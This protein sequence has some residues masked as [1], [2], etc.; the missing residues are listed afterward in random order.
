VESICLT[1]DFLE[2]GMVADVGFVFCG[3][4]CGKEVVRLRQMREN[5]RLSFLIARD[6][7]Q[8]AQHPGPPEPPQP[9]NA[10]TR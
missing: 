8:E 7:R 3:E 10:T 6:A 9:Y 2:I 1:L 4:K 5:L